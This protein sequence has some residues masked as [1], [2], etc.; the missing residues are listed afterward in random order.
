MARLYCFAVKK[1]SRSA[2]PLLM[3]SG[4][5]TRQAGCRKV[6]P[7]TEPKYTKAGHNRGKM[8]DTDLTPEQKAELAALA[9][10][11]DADI[12]TSDIPATKEFTNPRRG[13]F[14]GGPNRRAKN[15][16]PTNSE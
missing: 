11:P 8:R 13:V 4:P 10:L 9:S 5:F 16:H 2:G 12:D 7:S 3:R 1:P 6:G 14:S 15:G